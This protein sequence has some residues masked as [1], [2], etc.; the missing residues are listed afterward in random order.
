MAPRRLDLRISATACLRARVVSSQLSCWQ[1]GQFFR[2]CLAAAAA[3]IDN[4]SECQTRS[5]RRESKRRSVQETVLFF[6]GAQL[7]TRSPNPKPLTASPQSY[8]RI[9]Q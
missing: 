2:K 5:R 9:L 1:A 6:R 4:A 3:D 8:M 7:L